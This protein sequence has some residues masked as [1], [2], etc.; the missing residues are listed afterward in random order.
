MI[1][2]FITSGTAGNVVATLKPKSTLLKISRH[3]TTFFLHCW[4]HKVN[5]K[6]E[7]RDAAP[8]VIFKQLPCASKG[9][10]KGSTVARYRRP[11]LSVHPIEKFRTVAE[12]STV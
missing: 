7:H 8:L 11:T 10:L 2:K 12:L 6:E 1:G 3:A 5:S 4:S 9:S